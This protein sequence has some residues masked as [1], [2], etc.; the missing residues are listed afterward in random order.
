MGPSSGTLGLTTIYLFVATLPTLSSV[1]TL[2]V[3]CMYISFSYTHQ[4]HIYNT[5]T[6]NTFMF[7]NIRREP[8]GRNTHVGILQQEG[9]RKQKE[10]EDIYVLLAPTQS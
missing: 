7:P 4:I 3:R 9:A 5:H 1:Y 2:G 6:N 8:T 10:E